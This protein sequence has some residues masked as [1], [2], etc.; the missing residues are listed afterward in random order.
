MVTK[1]WWETLVV[2]YKGEG[3]ARDTE[4]E[5]LA[6]FTECMELVAV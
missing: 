6:E 1:P 4:W 2:D 3:M 5:G